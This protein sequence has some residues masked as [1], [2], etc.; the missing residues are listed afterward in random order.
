MFGDFNIDIAD[1]RASGILQAHKLT[2]TELPGGGTIKNGSKKVDYMLASG[3]VY[4]GLVRATQVRSVPFGPHFGYVIT[5]SGLNIVSGT[6]LHIPKPLPLE[7]YHI[8]AKSLSQE[9]IDSKLHNAKTKA[10][11][12]KKQ[13]TKTGFAILGHPVAHSLIDENTQGEVLQQSQLV[14]EQLA[15]NALQTELFTLDV[16]G[17]KQDQIRHYIGRSQFPKFNKECKTL[18]SIPDYVKA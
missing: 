5:F 13:K 17:I 3:I 8:K 4:T 16:A 1:L 6:K 11:S 2:A 7:D 9:D 18:M 12:F 15:L 10:I 14:E